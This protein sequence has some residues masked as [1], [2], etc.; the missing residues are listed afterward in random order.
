MSRPYIEVAMEVEE[1][2]LFLLVVESSPGDL[3]Q[4]CYDQRGKTRS[5]IGGLRYISCKNNAK[6]LL[7]CELIYLAILIVSM[8][9]W[10][11]SFSL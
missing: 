5:I 8:H 10:L 4:R 3:Q 9:A 2:K 11:I 6:F 7:S 1:E